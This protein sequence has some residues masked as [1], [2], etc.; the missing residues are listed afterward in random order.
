MKYF[1]IIMC[2]CLLL[3]LMRTNSFVSFSH[4]KFSL[5][6]SVILG[7]LIAPAYMLDYSSFL[8][9]GICETNNIFWYTGHLR[10]STFGEGNYYGIFLATIL[11]VF[12]RYNI[13][14]LLCCVG[15]F[16]SMSKIALIILFYILIRRYLKVPFFII[17]ATLACAALIVISPAEIEKF[18][19]GEGIIKGL[20]LEND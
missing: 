16:I 20:L 17:M 5:L 19:T 1:L 8:K 4:L 7:I 13:V 6:L 2:Y 14:V 3:I 10:C 11:I 15:I 9:I 12:Q 18:I